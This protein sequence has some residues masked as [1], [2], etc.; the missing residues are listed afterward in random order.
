[1]T[2]VMGLTPSCPVLMS[3]KNVKQVVH[4]CIWECG[5]AR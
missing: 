5:L 4:K 3:D 2:Q 1:V